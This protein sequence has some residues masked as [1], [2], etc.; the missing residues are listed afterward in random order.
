[1]AICNSTTGV[2]IDFNAAR[3]A[4]RA[5]PFQGRLLKSFAARLDPDSLAAARVAIANGFAEGKTTADIAH[6][7]ARDQVRRA[8]R[9][10]L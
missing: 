3:E 8:A 2:V 1:M 5:Q 4:R 7:I 9:A 6:A 10:S